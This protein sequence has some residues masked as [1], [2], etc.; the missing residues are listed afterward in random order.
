V[1]AA[2]GGVEQDADDPNVPSLSAVPQAHLAIVTGM[3]ARIDPVEAFGLTPGD[4]HVIRNA[5]SI[6]SD[7][8]RRS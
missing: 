3:D 6:V 7:D 5:G 1:R 4:A 2:S 8:V